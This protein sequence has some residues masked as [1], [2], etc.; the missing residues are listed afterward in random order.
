MNRRFLNLF[1]LGL[2]VACGSSAL[3]AEELPKAAPEG[4]APHIKFDATEVNLGDVIRG[5][6]AVAIFTYHNTGNAPLHILSAK[7]G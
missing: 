2:F 1:V 5:Q 3:L 4:P 6:D 7:P